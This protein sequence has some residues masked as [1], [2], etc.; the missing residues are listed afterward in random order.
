[1]SARTPSEA[2]SKRNIVFGLVGLSFLAA[3]GAFLVLRPS[4]SSGK[5]AGGD[6]VAVQDN[7]TK[8]DS[9]K[10]DSKKPDGKKL[11]DG[12]PVSNGKVTADGRAKT[13]DAN[14][15]DGDARPDTTV[16]PKHNDKKVAQ[17][18]DPKKTPKK[19]RSFLH[20]HTPPRKKLNPKVVAMLKQ[21][22]A[23]LA[24][25][26]ATQ[27]RHLA[28]RSMTLGGPSSS[29]YAIIAKSYCQQQNLGLARANLR[30]VHGRLKYR[31]KAYCKR[32][33]IDLID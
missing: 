31:V 5:S 6:R 13:D 1:M 30:N 28:R 18:A 17:N 7:A 14:N 25:G 8:P 20:H 26:N 4:G 33:G 15:K 22:N 2:G 10:R 9:K 24:G 27:A 32:Q 21:A 11:V 29:A 3:L 12:D 23:A 16:D 19:V